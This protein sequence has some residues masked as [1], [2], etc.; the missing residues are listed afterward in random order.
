[1]FVGFVLIV[2][3]FD[4]LNST[5]VI[6]PNCAGLCVDSLTTVPSC[7]ATTYSSCFQGASCSL[8]STNSCNWVIDAN[9]LN[10]LLNVGNTVPD[11]V[12]EN[13]VLVSDAS[14]LTDVTPTNTISIT[15]TTTPIT[16]AVT[17]D[18]ISITDTTTPINTVPI[19]DTTTQINNFPVT[20]TT[21]PTNIIYVTD[22][23]PPIIITSDITPTVFLNFQGVLPSVPSINTDPLQYIGQSCGTVEVQNNCSFENGLICN[24]TNSFQLPGICLP[25]ANIGQ[26]CGGITLYSPICSP[27]SICIQQQSTTSNNNGNH[28]YYFAPFAS[29]PSVPYPPQLVPPKINKRNIQPQVLDP[30]KVCIELFSGVGQ[31]CNGDSPY[32]FN[33]LP[34]LMCSDSVTVGKPSRCAEI[35]DISDP[36]AYFART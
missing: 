35:P 13:V 28:R 26:Q 15:D 3:L 33:C 36:T 24:P 18:T 10:C 34:G 12:L 11:S 25:V 29:I 14:I 9:A 27:N 6:S 19:T 17:P 23:T 21:T 30:L 1:M 22:T 32:F 4:V 2:C 16:D 8:N 31:E 7:D 20:D 5:C